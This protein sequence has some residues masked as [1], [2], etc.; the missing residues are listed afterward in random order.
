MLAETVVELYDIWSIHAVSTDQAIYR[1]QDL[2]PAF[3]SAVIIISSHPAT[4]RD[5][6]LIMICCLV[7]HFSFH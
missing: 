2:V 3:L 1:N 4:W 5:K 7:K 6:T